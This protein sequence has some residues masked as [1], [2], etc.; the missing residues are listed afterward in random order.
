MNMTRI[1]N[2]LL[3]LS[4]AMNS[5]SAKPWKGIVPL[6]STRTNVERLLGKPADPEQPR[7]YLANE[8]VT[9][10]YSKYGCDQAPVVKGWPILPVLWN[11]KPDLVTVISVDL[12]RPVPLSSLSLDLATFKRVPELHLRNVFRYKNEKDGFGIAA[13]EDAGIEMVR[14]YIYEPEAKYEHLRCP[15]V[16]PV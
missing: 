12:K 15:G 13:Y 5:V 6:E 11:V 3:L 2:P 4:I 10:Q 9:V 8:I 16:K 14:G 1:I 7:Y